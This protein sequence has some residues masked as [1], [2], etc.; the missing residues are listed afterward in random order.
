MTSPDK[1]DTA[2]EIRRSVESEVSIDP[3]CECESSVRASSIAVA[4]RVATAR[5][6]KLR[7]QLAEAERSANVWKDERDAAL[8]GEARKQ[9]EL[10]GCYAEISRLTKELA[11]VQQAYNRTFNRLYDIETEED[12]RV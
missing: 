4:V 12:G 1:T 11:N 2:A 10:N 9:A 6:E 7:A 8:D 3:T 5:E